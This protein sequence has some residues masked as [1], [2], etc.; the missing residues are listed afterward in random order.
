MTLAVEK[1]GPVDRAAFTARL[2]RILPD[3]RRALGALY[4]DSELVWT[5]VGDAL[6]YAAVRAE[7]LRRLD[8]AREAE[9]RWFQDPGMIGYVCYADRFAGSL[10][11]VRAQLDH[12]AE[13]GVTYLH[14]MPLL[15]AREG[16]ND[17]GYAVADYDAVDPRLGTMGDL[18]DL[19]AEL[20]RRGMVLCVDMVLNHT[21]REHPWTRAHRE[22]YL[23]FPDRELP[24]AYERTLPEI[25]PDLAPGNFTRDDQLGAWVWTTFHDYQW[26]LDHA[27][28]AVFRALLGVMLRLANRGVDVLRLD[29]VPFLGK[30]LGTDCQNQPEAHLVLQA[31]RALTRLAAPGLLLKAEAMVP[32]D[33]LGGYLGDHD[34]Y[35]PECDVAYD[36]QLMVALWS[37]A[38]TGDARLAAHALRRRRPAPERTCWATYL[39]C[40]DDI[41]WAID[42]TD[43][44]AAGTSG[45]AHR[46]FLSDF[47]A[48]RTAGSFARGEV[49]QRAGDGASP[50]SGT[51]AS[52]CGIEAALAGGDAAA[53]E[54][55][56][57]RLESL[58]SVVFSF[59]GIPLVYMG[60]ELA[61]RNDPAGRNGPD[62]RWIHRPPMDW[63]AAARRTRESTMEHRVFTAVRDLAAV[64]ARTPSLAS[65]APATVLDSGDRRL[66]AYLRG[67]PG[68]D[69]VLAVVNFGPDPVVFEA[70]LPDGLGRPVLLHATPGAEPL[71]PD[72]VR[73]PGCGFYWAVVHRT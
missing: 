21:A 6:E 23:T 47:Y 32:P 70:A 7:P 61:L 67:A 30:R 28:P 5:L 9:P 58:Y 62:N 22:F 14:L 49:F 24:D 56:L 13:L 48:G 66:L 18:V 8:R 12:L 69:P 51:T 29:A 72:G 39:R 3:A 68:G 64:R 55:A 20:H 46:R 31:F 65:S 45:P 52:L 17:G 42:D 15:K 2:E 54:L 26:D 10:R 57:R 34:P 59:G 27:N 71:G 60:D 19:A 4:G 63:A 37:A 36:N 44:A 43:A 38:A 53:L 1:L 40:H 11:G 35:R 33:L 50:I 16:D 73:V 41:G 25:F